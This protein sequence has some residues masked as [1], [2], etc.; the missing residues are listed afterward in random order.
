MFCFHLVNGLDLNAVDNF[1][2]VVHWYYVI[3]YSRFYVSET[4]DR[5]CEMLSPDQE[6]AIPQVEVLPWCP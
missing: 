4:L 5:A 6:Q 2:T 3:L 1:T